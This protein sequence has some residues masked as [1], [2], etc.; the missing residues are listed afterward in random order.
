M[1][2]AVLVQLEQIPLTA[3]GKIDRQALP[4][5]EG[6]PEIGGYVA[7][8]TAVE[9]TLAQIWREVLRLDQVGVED[10][11]FELGGN[12]LL[13]MQM[14]ARVHKQLGLDI[15]LPLLFARST[16][17]GLATAL[18]AAFPLNEQGNLVAIRKRGTH[19]PLFLVHDGSGSVRYAFNIARW[20]NAD[21]PIYGL[22]RNES[23]TQ[24]APPV[25][26]EEMAAVYVERIRHVQQQGPY[27]VAGWSAGGT[28]A[29]EMARQLIGS[30]AEV[31]FLGLID[32]GCG[33]EHVF[34]DAEL[35]AT[36]ENTG[37]A[38]DES[39]ALL[40]FL[41]SAAP[42]T[43][44]NR[45]LQLMAVARDFDA[46][47]D[48]ARIHDL[49]PQGVERE[50]VTGFLRQNH[51]FSLALYRYRPR[52]LPVRVSLFPAI[53]QERMDMSNGW[54]AIMPMEKLH[55]I[56]IRGTHHTMMADPHIRELGQAISA[57][58]AT[59]KLPEK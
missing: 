32:T 15:P 46:I 58:L 39:A 20:I 28:V 40:G 38:F 22:A 26:I 59:L 45:E 25:T 30:G 49:L 21:I 3:N 12:S 5:P 8:R 52:V 36:D 42:L 53:E 55:I 16:V 2:P 6:R 41:R 33:Y 44:Q 10:N 1:V 24:Q 37:P 43:S 51:E 54:N 18:Q 11:F 56:P 47:L 27:R 17:N 23:F 31:E 9:A 4:A 57:T 19:T 34:G 29:Y 50:L 7:P 35:A 13:A 48:Y 14:V